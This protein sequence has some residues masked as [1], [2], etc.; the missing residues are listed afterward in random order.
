[1][2]STIDKGVVN[3]FNRG[4]VSR[5]A[6]SREDITRVEN[7][8]ELMENWLPQRLGN[9]TFRSGTELIGSS[10]A[11]DTFMVPLVT[12]VDDPMLLLFGITGNQVYLRVIRNDEF[13]TRVGVSSSFQNGTF[14]SGFAAGEWV[15]DNAVDAPSVISA[16]LILQGLNGNEATTYQIVDSTDTGQRHGFTI[17]ITEGEVLCQMGTDGSGSRDLFERVLKV[18]E[19]TVQVTPDSAMTVTF[20]NGNDYEGIVRSCQ[21]F[22]IDGVSNTVSVDVATALGNVPISTTDTYAKLKTLRYAESGD[23]IYFTSRFFPPFVVSRLNEDSISIERFHTVFGPWENINLTGTTMTPVAPID[24]NMVVNSSTPFFADADANYNY[25]Y[26]TGLKLAITGQNQTITTTTPNDATGPIFVF[27]SGDARSFTGEID[28]DN[29]LGGVLLE[30]SFDKI[31]WQTAPNVTAFTGTAPIPIEYND[32]LDGVEIYYRLRLTAQDGGSPA[33]FNTLTLTY[34]YGVIEA[35]GRITDRYSNSQVEVEWYEPVD[36]IQTVS[37]WYIGSWGGKNEYPDAVALYEGRLWF[38]GGG[39]IWGSETDYYESFNRDIEGASAS[40]FRTIGF[41]ASQSIFWLAPSARMVAGTVLGEIDIKS[42]T[43]GEVLTPLNTNLKKG[44]DRGCANVIPLVMDQEI[45]FV[46]RGGD[47]LLGMDFNIAQEK[48]EIEDF[49]LIN[50]DVLSSGV[51]RLAYTRNPETRIYAVLNDGTMRVL[52]RDKVEDVMGW[53][54]V[55][56]KYYNAST[57]QVEN[58]NVTDVVSISGNTEDSVYIVINK[59]SSAQVMK[60]ANIADNSLYYFDHYINLTN[61]SSTVVLDTRFIVG[62]TVG[63]VVDGVDD[64]DYVVASGNQITGVTVGTDVT[65]GYRY[66]PTY[67]SNKMSSYSRDSVLNS[68]KRIINTGLI[69]RNYVLDGV[70]VGP[71]LDTMSNLPAIE[72]GK[73]STDKSDY[74]YLPFEYDGE[75]ETDPRIFIQATRPCTIMA[76]TY[77]VK[78]T[79]RK[80]KKAGG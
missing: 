73:A 74:D 22:T 80:T 62:S 72:E 1:M 17:L 69:M 14:S 44:S 37:D 57:Q 5:E 63:V 16:G 13:L 11:V 46:Q 60:F 2:T 64:G 49:N 67:K 45:I 9:M 10:T 23:Q 38:A 61:P 8:C 18:G 28:F 78:D 39:K 7:S 51:V 41:G 56:V 21:L 52:L 35:Q 65:V 29:T 47:R 43:F 66:T 55:S 26:G 19:H 34:D 15:D 25:S 30:K 58:A 4:E 24:G 32:E 79:D 54:T 77:E 70:Q 31:T 68:N 36:L 40:I 71:D 59:G 3:K 33:T 76:L 48:H 12:D 42:N 20:S 50:D 6:F 53:S 27:G 75:S